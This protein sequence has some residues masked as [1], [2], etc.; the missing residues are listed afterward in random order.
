MYKRYCIS[1]KNSSTRSKKPIL[2]LILLFLLSFVSTTFAADYRASGNGYNYPE[3]SFRASMSLDVRSSSLGTSWLKYYY[4]RL[5]LSL[6]STSI[7][8]IS[9]EGNTATVTGVGA[10]NEVPNYTFTVTITDGSPDA[11][12]IEIRKPNGTLHFKDP[13]EG[14]TRALSTGNF[15]MEVSP[16]APSNLIA[17]PI[18]S[19][20]INLSWTDNSNN[21]TGFKIERKLGV[22]GTYSQIA[23]VGANATTYADAVLLIGTVYYYRIKAYSSVG[24]SDYSNEASA[25]TWDSDQDND[26]LT[27]YEEGVFGTDPN[28]YDTD[29]DGVD[30]LN[31]IFPLDPFETKDSDRKEIQI[32]LNPA[33][34]YIP[35]I[36]GNRVVWEDYRNGDSDIY[37][38]DISTGV[39]T[40]VISDSSDQYAPSISGDRIVWTDYRNG[41]S[42]IYMY[43]IS[44]G[45]E[46]QITRDAADQ[47]LPAISGDSVIWLDNRNVNWDI[48]MYN[49]SKGI[50]SRININGIVDPWSYPAISGNRVLWTDN[51]NGSPAIYLYDISTGNETQITTDDGWQQHPAI[52]GN[53]IVWDDYR[54]GNADIYMYDIS[55]GDEIRITIN[56]DEQEYPDVSG[57]HI[58]WHDYRNGNSDIYIY[59]GDGVGDNSDNCPDIYNP[60]QL[61]SDGDGIGNVCDP[62]DD[63]DGLTDYQEG[64]IG[65]NPLNQDTDGDEIDDLNDAFPLE[66]ASAPTVTTNSPTNLNG[67]SATLNTTVNANG[68][69]TTVYFQWGISAPYGND[70]SS[71]SIGN[72]INNV[73]IS[74]NIT[75]LSPNTMYHYRVVAANIVGTSYSNDISFTTPPITLTIIYPLNN[76]TMYRPDIMV[77][78]TATNFTGNETGV[79]VN[80]IVA[81]IYHNEFI[82]NHVPLIEGS[83]T[84]TVTATDTEGNT[85]TTAITINAVPATPH[86]T[87][88]ANIE[89]GIA[90]LTTYFSVSTEISNAVAT[91]QMDFEGDGAIDYAGTTFENISYTYT[92]EGI[93]YPTVVVTDAG[94]STYSDTIAIIVL[95]A[96]DLDAL[97]QAK[98]NAMKTAL[99]AKNIEAAL[100]YIDAEKREIHRAKFEVLKDSMPAILDTFVEFNFVKFYKYTIEYEIVAN[101]NGVLYS[102]PIT[103][104]R[105]E[106]GIWRFRKF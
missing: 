4:T 29:G 5:R 33:D 3:P 75:N 19:T 8:G 27:N 77:R 79:V 28:N 74:A 102:Y 53:R 86:V 65:T 52:S 43:D 69:D 105:G 56:D 6:V 96:T 63:N 97:L 47:W 54:N 51:R 42:D 88:R 46:T 24:D 14:G 104:I 26:G 89:S 67:N 61:D 32:T 7:T 40:R 38:Y 91:Y 99:R 60:D 13:P 57:K 72:G 1:L 39:E 62:D 101:E 36:S 17:T 25:A 87:L 18:S 59:T 78:G 15:I 92:T 35:S 84:I 90:P 49:V 12:G 76:S 103:F 93:Y 41:N 2:A 68:A 106:D 85:V 66:P 58:T 22:D 81:N 73:S 16:A 44:T 64:L 70:T 98:W 82:V 95:N 83:N 34:Q 55:N 9:S 31:D 30:D 71:Q 23:D 80:G 11:M 48:Y 21:E 10:L 20:Q 45:V 94:G 50:E 100:N 37:M